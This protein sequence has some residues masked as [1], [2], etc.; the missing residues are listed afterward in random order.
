[1]YITGILTEEEI[2]KIKEEYPNLPENYYEF[3]KTCGY[4]DKIDDLECREF[5]VYAT[6]I[7]HHQHTANGY[8]L[9]SLRAEFGYMYI[10]YDPKTKKYWLDAD[11]DVLEDHE[12]NFKFQ[13][14]LQELGLYPY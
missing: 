6:P 11:G 14:L 12:K 9:C 13:D 10:G 3:M 1:M 5:S 7:E 2:T 4:S 8:Q